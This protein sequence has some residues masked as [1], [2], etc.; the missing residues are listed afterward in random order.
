ML[1]D[2]ILVDLSNV[3]T[4]IERKREKEASWVQQVKNNK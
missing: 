1:F 2:V 3:E 4:N